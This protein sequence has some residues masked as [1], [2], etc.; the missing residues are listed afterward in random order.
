MKAP[1]SYGFPMI[2][3]MGAPLCI[4]DSSN[5]PV[6]HDFL[7]PE[8]LMPCWEAADR[9][10]NSAARGTSKAWPCWALPSA[11]WPVVAPT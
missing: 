7:R 6:A 8:A 3:P 5:M 10:R 9:G 2:F 4:V 11:G 1:F